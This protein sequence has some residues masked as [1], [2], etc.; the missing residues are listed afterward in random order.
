MH[1]RLLLLAILIQRLSCI[2]VNPTTIP[3]P[4]NIPNGPTFLPLNEN[5]P[6]SL[7]PLW[8]N[9]I[10]MNLY[11]FVS[12][13][14]QF[15]DYNA[16]PNY[17]T[18]VRNQYSQ[19]RKIQLSIPK[20]VE[21]TKQHYYAHI[22]LAK[23][24]FPIDPTDISFSS[25]SI[26]YVCH[27]LTKIYKNAPH[28]HQTVT[29]S[30]V[31]DTKGYINKNTLHPI[32]LK[33]FS[34][35]TKS[36][37]NNQRR[38]DFYRPV[39]F[40]NDFWHI[41]KDAFPINDTA[42][43]LPL[44]VNLETINVW[45]FNVYAVL[46]SNR[47][48]ENEKQVNSEMLGENFSVVDQSFMFTI[49]LITCLMHVVFEFLAF[50]NDIWFYKAKTNRIGISVTS[51]MIHIAIQVILFT[52]MMDFSNN[53][54]RGCMQLIHLCVDVWKL[55]HVW[56]H[57][58]E[59]VIEQGS[60]CRFTVKIVRTAAKV[61]FKRVEQGEMR[62]QQ[63]DVVALK[64]LGLIALPTF[65]AYNAYHY[66]YH[67]NMLLYH[68]LENMCMEEW[69]KKVIINGFVNFL[70]IFGPAMVIGPQV[71]INYKMKSVNNLSLNTMIYK[72]INIVV[73]D[74]FVF[75]I[76]MP[77]MRRISYVKKNI[78]YVIF[79]L[80]KQKGFIINIFNKMKII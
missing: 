47:L 40:P 69:T 72:T 22:F 23:D 51:M 6:Q 61:K 10:K 54:I 66:Y 3:V 21:S 43:A 76:H 78:V 41:K 4:R 45:K 7:I 71:Y 25:D 57:E 31:Y 29:I 70:S 11:L 17:K 30:L 1:L 44:T 37:T 42:D 49:T 74:A 39:I 64:C 77:T 63:L 56:L 68:Q 27:S 26:V 16:T 80:Q 15:S 2:L 5:E 36:I 8:K 28:W 18:S 48:L 59:W 62:T 65:I 38:I 53:A 73:D 33:Y 60:N 79:L 67:Y 20:N 58:Y 50:K 46:A 13:D 24:S 19:D 12:T 9:N 35:T 75:M 52:Y 34:N 14:L 55:N 32:T